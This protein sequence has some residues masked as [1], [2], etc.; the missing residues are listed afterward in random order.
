MRRMQKPS[1]RRGFRRRLRAGPGS[2]DEGLSTLELLVVAPI[3]LVLLG[4]LL[5][6]GVY[7]MA[8]TNAHTAARKGAATAAMHEGSLADGTARANAWISQIGVVKSASISTAG[9]TPDR[10]RVTVRGS[11]FVMV[12]GLE[13]TV[14]QS[15]EQPVERADV[16]P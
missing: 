7:A 13:L 3:S 16:A 10:V 11:V 4:A 2:R 6:W 15:A 14:T 12:P 5:Q 8:Q 9:S 1:P